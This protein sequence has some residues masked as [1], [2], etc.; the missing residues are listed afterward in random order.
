MAEHGEAWT[1]S[2]QGTYFADGR[3]PIIIV[4]KDER[5]LINP[6]TGVRYVGFEMGEINMI[7]IKNIDKFKNSIIVLD[8]MGSEFSRHMKYYFIEG[9][10]NNFQM[11][12]MCH[13]P[14]QIDNMSTMN[15][16]TLYIPTYNGPHLFQ[17]FK[18]T[19]KCDHK[20]LEIVSELNSS[21]YNCT[22]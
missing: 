9:R 15:C 2:H 4:C 1:K 16:D 13:K 17:N 11:I 8:D 14:A 7:T 3:R 10:H 6:E 5:D 19:F 20:F 12:V 18:T 22:Y 21:Y